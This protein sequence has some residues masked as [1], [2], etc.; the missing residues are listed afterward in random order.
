MTNKMQVEIWSDIMCPFC[1][2][3]KR[4]FEAALA[5]FADAKNLEITWKS[6]QLDPT[7]PEK[8]ELSQE[9][10]LVERK[11][12][13]KEQVEN[14]LQQLTQTAK[15]AGLD[16][17]FNKAI[18]VNSYKAH[19]LI[20]F[21][22]SKGLGDAAEEQLFKAFFTEGKDIADTNTL[23]ELGAVIG[24]TA[25]EVRR[26]LD[27]DQY[28]ALVDKD[29]YEAKQL[30]IGGVPFF[31]FNRKYAV[32]G[33]QPPAAFTHTVEKAFSEWREKNPATPFEVTEGASCTP[34]GNC[35]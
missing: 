6:F 2:I 8:Q 26:A 19:R 12:I 28:A 32:S 30:G 22:K 9:Q 13:P 21:A 15:A 7:L 5:N 16:F 11:G 10:Y 3:G 34:D 14:M 25:E 35:G 17:N 4:N 29:L 31:V 1:Y 27:D 24:L 20:Q 33:A 18:T 23:I